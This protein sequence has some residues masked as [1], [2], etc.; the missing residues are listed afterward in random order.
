LVYSRFNNLNNLI[1]SPILFWFIRVFKIW[2]VLFLLVIWFYNFDLIIIANEAL[3]FFAF[4]GHLALHQQGWILRHFS[5]QE[6]IILS[7]S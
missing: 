7:G 5:S 4:G 6:A 1:L 3:L 2:L